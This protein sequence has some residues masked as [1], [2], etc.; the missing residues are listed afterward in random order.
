MGTKEKDTC[1]VE[2]AIDVSGKTEL[3]AALIY[4]RKKKK[5]ENKANRKQSIFGNRWI[6]FCRDGTSLRRLTPVALN[7]TRGWYVTGCKLLARLTCWPQQ[8]LAGLL[9][10]RFLSPGAASWSLRYR[11][12]VVPSRCVSVGVSYESRFRAEE[13]TRP[14]IFGVSRIRV[15]DKGDGIGRKHRRRPENSKRKTTNEER[16]DRLVDGR[17]TKRKERGEEQQR[18]GFPRIPE[19]AVNSPRAGLYAN[20]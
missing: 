11:V 10:V 2:R 4:A 1:S 9:S 16:V 19:H 3:N 5:D 18:Q 17:K 7:R 6:V 14:L 20:T 13:I 15:K 8:C 12:S